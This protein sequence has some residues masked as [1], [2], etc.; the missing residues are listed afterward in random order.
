MSNSGEEDG[1]DI[2]PEL[3]QVIVRQVVGHLSRQ[4]GGQSRRIHTSH[5]IRVRQ[6]FT[7]GYQYAARS[8]GHASSEI[9]QLRDRILEMVLNNNQESH[10][11]RIQLER[12]QVEIDRLMEKVAELTRRLDEETKKRE[13]FDTENVSL[14]EK[15]TKLQEDV[16]KLQSENTLLKEDVAALLARREKEAFI[17]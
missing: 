9:S 4:E 15:V 10:N 11:F 12:K 2:D 1:Q 17:H 6:E 13:K 3:I 7:R 5:G 8:V 14:H 16:L